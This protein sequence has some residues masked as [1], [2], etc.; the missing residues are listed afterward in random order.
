MGNAN[1]QEKKLDNKRLV[2]LW[3]WSIWSTL[4]SQVAKTWYS[5]W[6][7][8]S[9]KWSIVS[10]HKDSI[11]K[12][13]WES[14]E[15]INKYIIENWIS[16]KSLFDICDEL[17]WIWFE[18]IVIDVS[19]N[20]NVNIHK[21]LLDKWFKVITANKYQ[22]SLSDYVDAKK[23]I[24]NP[25]YWYDTTVMAGQWA[26]QR[27][28]EEKNTD[29]W[30][31]VSLK[32]IFSWTLAYIS[33]ELEKGTLLSQAVEN[34]INLKYTEPNPMDD[35]DWLD[36]AKKLVI[37]ARTLWY[38]VDLNHVYVKWILEDSFKTIFLKWVSQFSI[39]EFIK[40]IKEE[41][42]ASFAEMVND[43]KPLVPRYV[44]SINFE[45]KLL[46][47]NVWLEFVDPKSEL[48]VAES[49][50]LVIWIDRSLHEKDNIVIWWK[51]AWPLVTVSWV[52]RDIKRIVW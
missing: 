15:W 36:V 50:K 8:V 30:K 9:M 3:T 13:A 7:I 17:E 18:P 4:L 45:W 41:K 24:E 42:D 22:V 21:M 43:Y 40:K 44:A 46:K 6:A 38:N 51:W 16:N 12:L 5:V 1:T 32:W 47:L 29:I 49:N 31:I 35:L 28:K 37:L 33:K 23:M 27:L 10:S 52:I 11:L 48:W 34:A 20:S 39:D 25:W 19:N 26:I 2:I 14:R